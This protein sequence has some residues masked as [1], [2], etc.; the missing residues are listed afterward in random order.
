[1]TQP[2]LSTDD[3]AGRS[4][5]PQH[6]STQ[7]PNDAYPQHADAQAPADPYPST[8]AQA[9]AD[10]YPA[11][12]AQAP[13]DAYPAAGAQAPA[14]SYPA[15]GAEQAE[16]YAPLLDDREADGF[17]DRWRDVQARFVDDPQEAVRDGDGLVAELMQALAQRFS[18]QK[19]GLQEHWD[20]GGAPD[21]EELRRALQEYRSFFH[22]LLST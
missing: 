19:T 12:A 2:G 5:D 14:D 17:L 16:R 11:T 8:D 1:M 9:P 15:A 4:A 20:R 7:V 21:T 22:R 13:A 10:A 6:G 18:E 3:L